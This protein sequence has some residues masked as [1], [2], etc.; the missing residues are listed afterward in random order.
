MSA[1]SGSAR[2]SKPVPISTIEAAIQ[3]AGTALHWK[4]TAEQILRRAGVSQAGYDRYRDL[5]KFQIFRSIFDDLDKAGA[6]GWSVQQNIV[7]EL[8]GLSHVEKKAPDPKAGEKALNE[9]RTIAQQEE[10]LVSPEDAERVKR[11]TENQQERESSSKKRTAIED[12]NAEFLELH[13]SDDRQKRGYSLERILH[14][15]FRLNELS[16]TGSYR[17]ETD[18]VDGSFQLESFTYLLEAKWCD[19]IAMDAN[20]GAFSHKVERR[21]DATRGLYLSMNSFRDEVVALY[22]RAKENKVILVDGT[23]LS[24]ILNGTFDFDEAIKEKV[25]AASIRGEPFLRL[26]EF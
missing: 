24:L 12:L 15:L 6:R 21:L 3:A 8:A 11:R 14:N 13:R 7:Q 1:A 26:G 4:R 22:R 25:R 18:Q 16:Y 17:T 9:L 20:L 19:H 23:D 5:S 10:V 2:R